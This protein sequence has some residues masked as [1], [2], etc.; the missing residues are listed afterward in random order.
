MNGG[1]HIPREYEQRR[2]AE[3]TAATRRRIVEA[4]LELH[5]TIGFVDATFSAVAE[6]AGVQRLTLYRHF[7]TERE[8][9][10]ACATHFFSEHRLPDSAAWRRVRDPRERLQTALGELYPYYRATQGP[11][12]NFL[13]DAPVKPFLYEL[14]APL[15]EELGQ[16]RAVLLRGWGR[17]GRRRRELEAAVALAL[18]FPTWQS[19]TES[20]GLSDA[21]AAAL[22]ARMVAAA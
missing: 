8:L 6:R 17:R 2:R 14:G 22:A 11:L 16:M 9:V 1:V 10:G 20:Q 19:L 4:A 12:G 3:Q 21:E 13:R 15:F 18:A 5:G 7:P